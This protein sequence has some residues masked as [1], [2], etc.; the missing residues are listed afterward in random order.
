MIHNQ[1]EGGRNNLCYPYGE[2]YFLEHQ[3]KNRT[4]MAVEESEEEVKEGK[5]A[6]KEEEN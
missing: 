3:C 5:E 2:R 1:Q 4:V 6:N